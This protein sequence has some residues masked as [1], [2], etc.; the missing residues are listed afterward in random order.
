MILAD[1]FQI[2]N[3]EKLSFTSLAFQAEYG[4][5]IDNEQLPTDFVIEHYASNDLINQVLMGLNKKLFCMLR[6]SSMVR[7]IYDKKLL[8]DIDHIVN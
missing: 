2:T 6:F 3:E 1:T 4:D 8:K 7:K 5:S